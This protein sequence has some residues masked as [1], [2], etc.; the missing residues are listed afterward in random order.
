MNIVLYGFPEAA[1]RRIARHYALQT[2]DAPEEFGSRGTG[3]LLH[4]RRIS[5]N[6]RLLAFYNALLHHEERIDAVI[7][8]GV[9]GCNMERMLPYG[10][11]QSKFY[12]LSGTPDE[13]SPLDQAQLIRHASF[14]AGNRISPRPPLPPRCRAST[15]SPDKSQ[16]SSGLPI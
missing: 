14:A 11:A 6:E 12:S 3:L 8:C 5:S 2:I 9:E 7:V 4:A 1:T 10:P 13:A 15:C 16:D